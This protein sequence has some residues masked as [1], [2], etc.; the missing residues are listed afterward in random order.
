M[1]YIVDANTLK[2]GATI[3]SG[4]YITLKRI[5]RPT[6]ANGFQVTFVPSYLNNTSTA[7]GLFLGVKKKIMKFYNLL[8]SYLIFL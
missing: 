8:N 6:K 5:N 2:D 1:F 4:Y 7:A 3:P